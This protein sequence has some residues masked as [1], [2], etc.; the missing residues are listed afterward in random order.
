MLIFNCKGDG[1]S[2]IALVIKDED[3]IDSRM[4][5]E[6]YQ[7]ARFAAS[8]R[9]KLYRGAVFHF[10]FKHLIILTQSL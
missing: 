3:M 1:D 4:N 5:G 2:E 10:I 9:R 7:A 6:P 8:M